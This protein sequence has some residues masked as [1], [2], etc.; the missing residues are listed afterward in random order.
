MP[1]SRASTE[2][3][4]PPSYPF[5][6]RDDLGSLAEREGFIRQI[7]PSRNLGFHFEVGLLDSP[8]DLTSQAKSHRARIDPPIHS[9]IFCAAESLSEWKCSNRVG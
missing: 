5:A 3:R 9:R 6:L 2:S 8:G 4:R 1:R 7:I